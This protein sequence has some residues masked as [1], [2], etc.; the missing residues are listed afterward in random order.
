[1]RDA[2]RTPNLL[3]F[4]RHDL[5]E[6]RPPGDGPAVLL[7]G[8]WPDGTA[9]ESQGSLDDEIDARFLW[10]DGAASQLAERAAG[11]VAAP[12]F[13]SACDDQGFLGIDPAWLNAL[14]LRY[15]LVKL[16]RLVA[17]FTE[18]RPLDVYR[19]VDLVAARRRDEDYVSCMAE[20]CR[21]GGASCRVRWVDRPTIPR[22]VFP[23]NGRWRR[24]LAW[25]CRLLDPSPAPGGSQP[26]VVL[27]GNPRFLD[28]VC[29]ELLRRDA[30][31]WWLYD[32][33]AIRSWLRWRALGVGQ[34]VCR[35]DAAGA[36]RLLPASCERLECRGVNLAQPVRQWLAD[37]LKTYGPRQ[38]RTIEQIDAHLRRLRPSALVVDEDGT[39]MVRAAVALA[40]RH[41]AT[42]FVV[43]HGAPVCRFGFAPL[44][45]DWMLAWGRSSESQL[46]RWGLP[47]ERILAVGSPRH[48]RLDQEP[49]PRSCEP[50]VRLTG[51]WLESS[52]ASPQQAGLARW[53]R[54][55]K[56]RPECVSE[57][58]AGQGRTRFRENRPPRFLLLATTP[59]R[60][61]RPDAVALYLTARSYAEMLRSALA[62]V[63]AVPGAELIVKLHPRAPHDPIAHAVLAEFPSLRSRVV[64]RGAVEPWLGRIDCVLSCFS[65]AGI[66]ATLAGVPVIQLLP[67]GSGDLLP[68]DQW[69]VLGS[70]RSEAELQGLLHRALQ[71]RRTSPEGRCEPSP[72]P[73][74]FA[75]LGASAASRIADVIL[76]ARQPAQQGESLTEPTPQMKG[77]SQPES[78]T[79]LSF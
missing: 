6:P 54:S 11:Q 46:I 73:N 60:D 59:P 40:R 9:S 52:A 34:L 15:Y 10:I 4:A 14:A 41:G 77:V 61:E 37:R 71:T 74:V 75:D 69:A 63:S 64:R 67:P 20:L 53:P 57:H 5:V 38:T 44:A 16:I 30:R 31:V 27:C 35:S 45:A 68:H 36:N 39:P 76:T 25:L 49:G 56:A 8:S 22:Q 47:A 17:Y 43:Q 72:V 2:P 79:E 62:G 28:P 1:M 65:S 70:A 19:R 58:R 42:S 3:V 66:D 51:G 21:Q 55:T 78:A 24:G 26:R 18:V 13:A 7:E 29:R 23:A 33:F 32:R 48:Q 12:R 50:G